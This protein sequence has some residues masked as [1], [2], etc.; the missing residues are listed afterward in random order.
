MPFHSKKSFTFLS[1]IVIL[2]GFLISFLVGY[3]ID[4]YYEE[5]ENASL[6]LASNEIT[7]AIKARMAGYEQV[8]KSGVGLFY[9]SDVVSRS[10][11]AVFVKQ[12]RL[13]EDF[14]GIQGLGYSEIV[15]PNNKQAYEENIRK[16]GFPDFK[17]KPSGQREIY[18]S[19]TYLEPFTERN[20]RAFGYDMFSEEIRREAMQKAMQ[21]GEATLSGKIKLIQEFGSDI[22]AGFLMYLPVY[23]KGFK[24]DTDQDRILA[25]QGFVYAPFRANDLMNGLLGGKFPQIDFEIYDGADLKQNLLYDS[26][27]EHQHARVHRKININ[28]NNRDWTLVFKAFGNSQDEHFYIIFLFPTLILILTFLLYL[29]LNSLYKTKEKAQ[30]IALELTQGLHDSEERLRFALEGAGDGLWDWNLVTN[31]AFFSKRWK[32]ML[33]YGENE[34]GSNIDEWKSRLHPQDREDV[35]RSLAEHLEGKSELYNS[36]HRA[37]CKDGSY[38]WVLVRGVIVSRDMDGHPLRIV[39]SQADISTQ[40]Q[41]E[42][43]LQEQRNRFSL[44]VEGAQD[45]LWDWNVQ[46]NELWLSA[47]FETMLGYN[48]GDLPREIDSWFGLLHPEDKDKALKFVNDY[49]DS[50]GSKHYESTFRL[51]AKDGSWRWILGRGKAMFDKNGKPL[52]FVGFNTDISNQKDYQKKLDHIAKHDALTKLPNRFL[53]SELL[54]H[55]MHSVKRTNQHLALL[56]IDLDGFKI[57]NDTYGHEAGDFLLNAIAHRMQAVVRES[58]IVS[59]LGGDE[60]VIVASELKNTIEVTPLLQRLL[61]EL[62]SN[63]LYKENDLRVSASIGVSFYPQTVDVGNE[64]LLRQADQAMYQAKLL[65]KNQYQFFNLESSKELKEQ[66][67]DIEKIRKAIHEEE[68]VLHY[69]PK[70]NM[71]KNKVIGFEALLRWND[72]QNGLVYPESFLPLVEHDSSIMVD[73]GH[74]VFETALSQLETWHLA[75]LDITLS[76]NVS[77]HELQHENFVEY[78][79]KLLTKHR[80]IKPNSIEI[81]I[82]ETLAFENFELTSEILSQCS[83]MG[84]S[85][86]IDDFGTGYASL[87]YLKKLPK[88]TLKIDKSFVIDLLASSQNMSIVEATIG[89]ANAFNSHVVA[90]GVE[91]ENL[92]KMLLQLGCEIAQ[93]FVISEAMPAQEVDGWIQS[94]KGFSSW[95]N[96]KPLNSQ[97]RAILHTEVE[98]KNWINA[99]EA[100]IQNKTAELPNLDSSHCYLGNWLIHES[101][102]AQ[103]E[104]PEFNELKEIHEHLHHYAEK[105]LRSSKKD[106]QAGIERI[107]K[108][109]KE[110]LVKLKAIMEG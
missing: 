53:L 110:I 68:F 4:K 36:E 76:I 18:T 48:V 19:I 60:F 6:D 30:K 85:I 7:T 46:T 22:Q 26:N 83:S 77:S 15:L 38:K 23:K 1:Y 10:E 80:H 67:Q 75:G 49:L 27:V 11:W 33:G 3:L 98:H 34:I 62:S 94:W 64:V 95:E 32:E 88:N 51:R 13:D 14:K 86:A 21:E 100:F 91:S 58:D 72:P 37:K 61:T 101:S 104:H 55:E 45:G 2:I 71:A 8:L 43:E 42:R 97:N 81:E 24:L 29:L 107:V 47:R 16:E 93:G 5:K 102:K 41:I 79:Q 109:H 25:T 66:Q 103:R 52:R 70:V 69:Q 108:L 17:I 74:W 87:N 90:E 56:F 73:L 28:I 105:L 57:I 12:Q 59:R 89:L 63:V 35:N 9:A 50:K 106:K 65:G 96:V 78:L 31:D 20:Q 82:L 54:A 84:V 92:G 40:K 99:I 39:G 44:A